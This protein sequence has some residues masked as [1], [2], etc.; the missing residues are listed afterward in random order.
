MISDQMLIETYNRVFTITGNI[1]TVTVSPPVQYIIDRIKTLIPCN[2][3]ASIL[4]CARSQTDEK[5]LE[6]LFKSVAGDFTSGSNALQQN[7]CQVTTD[8]ITGYLT[9]VD[10]TQENSMVVTI[11]L[12][13]VFITFGYVIYHSAFMKK[14][15]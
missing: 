9:V 8:P 14:N 11:I 3:T 1:Q 5:T 2:N 4:D 6:L 13:I 12:V 15:K 7:F 10:K